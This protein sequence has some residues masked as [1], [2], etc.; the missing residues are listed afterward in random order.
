MMAF[1]LSIRPGLLGSRP[2][3]LL[4]EDPGAILERPT[5]NSP[6]SKLLYVLNG[7]VELTLDDGKQ[8]FSEL[9]RPGNS[10]YFHTAHR[11]G[12][13]GVTRSPFAEYAAEAI[14]VFWSP[15]GDPGLT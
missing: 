10:V 2:S 14:A 12:L 9:L 1:E 3:C 11:H 13:A 15:T 8:R 5:V 6:D 4:G 7:E